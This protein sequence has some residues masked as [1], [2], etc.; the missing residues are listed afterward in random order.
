M[1]KLPRFL[2]KGNVY[3]KFKGLFIV[4]IRPNPATISIKTIANIR[5]SAHIGRP[6]GFHNGLDG[7][8]DGAGAGDFETGAGDLCAGAGD[9]LF[10]PGYVAIGPVAGEL[11][12]YIIL[13]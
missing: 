9:E 11:I 6:V 7:M 1:K 3:C 5:V 2:E 10:T 4:I 12:F 8:G 13:I